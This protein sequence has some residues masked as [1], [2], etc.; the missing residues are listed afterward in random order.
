MTDVQEAANEN[1]R[2]RSKKDKKYALVDEDA[3]TDPILFAKGCPL[4]S[5]KEFNID[6]DRSSDSVIIINLIEEWP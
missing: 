6:Y 5:I 2:K 1:K 4:N 3:E